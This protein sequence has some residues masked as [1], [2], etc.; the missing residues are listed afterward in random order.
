MIA[1]S[2]SRT[3][4]AS[5]AIAAR[6]IVRYAA[7]GFT[8]STTDYGLFFLLTS[9]WGME[10]AA[11]NLVS[12]PVSGITGFLMHK[13]FTFGNRGTAATEVQFVRFWIVWVAAFGISQTMVT[14]YHSLLMFPPMLAKLGAEGAAGV[15]SFICQRNWTFRH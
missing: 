14:V 7:T 11:A 3:G 6:D 9:V 15:F 4:E 12:R 8:A 5:L 2:S 13:Y 10:P 1:P